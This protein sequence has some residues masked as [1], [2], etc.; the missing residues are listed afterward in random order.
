MDSAGTTNATNLFQLP[1]NDM[2]YDVT[3]SRPLSAYC[4]D[5]MPWKYIVAITC[6]CVG[7]FL[8]GAF[9]TWLA[10]RLRQKKRTA[11]AGFEQ[12]DERASSPEYIGKEAMRKM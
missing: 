3:P 7:S 9:A 5:S 10:I 8:L 4:D 11:G 1:V 2:G 12:V 6:G